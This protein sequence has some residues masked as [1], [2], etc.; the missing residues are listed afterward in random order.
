MWDPQYGEWHGWVGTH[1]NPSGSMAEDAH[2]QARRMRDTARKIAW[3]NVLKGVDNSANWMIEDPDEET[4]RKLAALKPPV[5][6]ERS[7][8]ARRVA[9]MLDEVVKR[10]STKAGQADII[11]QAATHDGIMIRLDDQPGARNVLNFTDCTVS[12]ERDEEWKHHPGDLITH[13]LPVAYAPAAQCPDFLNLVWRMTGKDGD[14]SQAHREMYFY[15]LSV[16][17]YTVIYGN[18][19]QLVFFLT[20]KT[21]TGKTTVIEIIG[22][23]LGSLAHKA[24]PLLITEPPRGELHDSIRWSVRGKRLVYVDETRRRMGVDVSAVKDLSGGTRFTVRKLR[25]AGE[26]RRGHVHHRRSHQRDAVDDR[27]G[28]GRR[29]ADRQDRVRRRDDPAG[30]A[31]PR[32]SREDCQPGRPGNP[33]AARALRPRVLPVRAGDAGRGAAGQRAVRRG[34]EHGHHLAGRVLHATGRGGRP[35]DPGGPRGAVEGV[36]AL[37]G[38]GPHLDRH[39]FYE[40]VRGWPGVTEVRAPGAGTSGASGCWDRRI[41]MQRSGAPLHQ[42]RGCRAAGQTRSRASL[43]QLVQLNPYFPQH[44]L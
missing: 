18:P 43:V 19:E 23:L 31:R 35:G 7:A 16:L 41:M 27:R 4:K 28:R 24:R 34:R 30:R 17:A 13:C 26:H 36:R 2:R 33:G 39:D 32:P 15:V 8:S 9:G 5:T 12:I 44:A 40:E 21:K 14:S 25:A 22:T 6:V 11:G 1:W 3:A 10:L 42:A 29:R 37:G 20:G 38:P